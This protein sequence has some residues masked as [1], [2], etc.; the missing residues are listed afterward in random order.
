MYVS[1]NI[2]INIIIIFLIFKISSTLPLTP[3]SSDI[4]ITTSEPFTTNAKI[5]DNIKTI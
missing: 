2:N 3:A 1:N 5:I 4:K